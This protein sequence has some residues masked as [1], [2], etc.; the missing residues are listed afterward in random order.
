MSNAGLYLHI[1]FC[2]RKCPYC[3]FYSIPM[4]PELLEQYTSAVCR[5][6]MAYADKNVTIDTVY[7]GG[8]TPS[9][10]LP[11]HIQR[12][13]SA[14]AS[15]FHLAGDTEITLEA[16][17]A[18]VSR[19]ALGHL[20]DCGVNRLSLGVQSLDAQQL[21][22]LGRLHTAEDAIQTVEDAVSAGF[23]NISCDLMLAL[24]EQ[25]TQELAQ[26][27]RRLT[28]LPITHI[29]AYLLKVESG[30]PFAVQQ[31]AE[32]CPD[33]DTSADFYL[34]TVEA[35]AKA[36]FAQYEISNFAKAGFESRHNCKYWRCEPY[37]GI[38]PSAH[39]C[40]N[41]TRFFVPSALSDFLEAPVQPTELE[42]ENPCTMEEKLM[43]GLRL[44][45]GVPADW[46]DASHDALVQ[47][48]CRV[49]YL[50]RFENRIAMTPQGFLVSNS[51]LSELL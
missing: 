44:T 13:L 34:Q 33:G 19:T 28:A 12:I 1:P 6:L 8:G 40:W 15:A 16:N 11:A 22:R 25:T 18:T 26:T 35:L 5:N 48:L 37:L 29:S 36:G 46:I 4:Q 45:E 14:A 27:I 7:F 41:G 21:K 24:P 49:G 43:L 3:N 39:S 47:Q 20:H 30:T 50:C 9:L 17:P 32:R 23:A 31:V 51:I 42:D 2:L 38:G 10:L